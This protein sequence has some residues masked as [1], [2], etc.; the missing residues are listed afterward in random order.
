MRELIWII[1]DMPITFT[2]LA[3]FFLYITVAITLATSAR[4]DCW[5]KGFPEIKST[6]DLEFVCVGID[7]VVRDR[8]ERPDA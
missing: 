5:A 1:R 7:G 3:A 2:F 6:I 4:K 8:L